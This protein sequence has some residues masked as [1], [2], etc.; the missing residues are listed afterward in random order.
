MA[1]WGKRGEKE[2]TMKKKSDGL[3]GWRGGGGEEKMGEGQGGEDQRYG[4]RKG[5][6]RIA[7]R[8]FFPR[9]KVP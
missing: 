7:R 1:K 8:S 3:G 4:L 5:E 2:K 6:S 9:L